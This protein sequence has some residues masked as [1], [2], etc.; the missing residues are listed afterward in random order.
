MARSQRAE[1]IVIGDLLIIKL[2]DK[3]LAAVAVYNSDGQFERR[4]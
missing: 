2:M 1:K 4:N 3:G